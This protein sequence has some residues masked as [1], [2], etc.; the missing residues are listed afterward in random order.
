M[1][2][3][4]KQLLVDFWI[5]LAFGLAAVLLMPQA[6]AALIGVE[7]LE[8]E[9][10]KGMLERPE[11]VQ[12]LSKAGIAV[13]AARAR[14]VMRDED[15]FGFIRNWLDRDLAEKLDLFVFEA[16]QDDE[17]RVQT[18][19]LEAVREAILAPKFNFGA[20]RVAAVEIKSD[21]GL[22]LAHEHASD[23][24]GLDAARAKKVL[25]YTRRVWRRPVRLH[26]VNDRGET[27]EL[28]A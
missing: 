26:T 12:Q 6:N 2:Q 25:E 28:A 14:E 22:I 19:D 3:R 18:R 4:I 8:R 23:G 21:G 16:R 5:V 7:D 13:E 1:I 11:L 9:R 10:V 27:I 24:R 20:P 17:I 15:D